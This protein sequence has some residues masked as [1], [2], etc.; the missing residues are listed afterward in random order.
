MGQ[1]MIAVLPEVGRPRKES[2]ANRILL[3]GVS[4]LL[5]CAMAA[6]AADPPTEIDYQGRISVGQRPFVGTGYFKYAITDN[7]ENT[8]YWS[9]DATAVGEPAASYAQT[10]NDGR[11]STLL[12]APPMHPIDPA[13]LTAGTACFF[14]VWFSQDGSTFREL[15]PKQKVV[16]SPFALNALRL[17]GKSAECYVQKIAGVVSGPLCVDGAVGIG[18]QQPDAA[19]HVVGSARFE[20]GIYLLRPR[21]DML[22]GIYTNS[23]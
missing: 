17:G 20:D 13:A 16:S 4:G 15:T 10:V 19:L 8:N 3:A 14:R 5:L 9:N 6:A 23:Q 18:T 2:G 21:G 11:F 22:M 12:G 7:E 1:E